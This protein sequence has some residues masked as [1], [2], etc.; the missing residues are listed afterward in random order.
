MEHDQQTEQRIRERAYQ[1][2]LEQGS[3]KADTMITG[4]RLRRN[5]CQATRRRCNL[6]NPKL[7]LSLAGSIRMI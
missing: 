1:I 3:P 5:S 7:S 6:S 2:W 4:S